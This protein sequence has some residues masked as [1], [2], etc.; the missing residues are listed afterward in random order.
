MN[1][2]ISSALGLLKE[3]QEKN[4]DEVIDAIMTNETVS[5]AVLHHLNS[6]KKTEFDIKECE[7]TEYERKIFWSGMEMTRI[8]L[9]NTQRN[10]DPVQALFKMLMEAK[11]TEEDTKRTRRPKNGE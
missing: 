3:W 7:I 2:T 6:L 1:Q 4:I 5:D 10:N 11:V 9:L 8:L